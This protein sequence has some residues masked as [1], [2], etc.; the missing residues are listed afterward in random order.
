MRPA[1]PRAFRKWAPHETLSASK[2]LVFNKAPDQ[3]A[4]EGQ[5]GQQLAR[6]DD[7]DAGHWHPQIGQRDAISISKGRVARRANQSSRVNLSHVCP[8]RKKK[9]FASLLGRNSFTDTPRPA[10]TRGAYRDRHE[11]WGAGCDGRL[12]ATDEG[13]FGGR[14]SRVVLMPRRWHQ[15]LRKLTLPRDDGDNQARSPERA[16]RKPLKPFAQGMPDRFGVP[17]VTML[18]CFLDL[19]TRLWVQRAPGIPCALCFG[20][21]H[22]DAKTRARMR[23]GNVEVWLNSIH[24]VPDKRAPGNV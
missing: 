19:R 13:A 12:R 10:S 15:V 5:G 4:D 20:A 1:L 22:G 2:P 9:F 6:V 3:P 7:H 24:A 16:R 14:R 8:A 23:R 11:T 21:G 17:V 18:V